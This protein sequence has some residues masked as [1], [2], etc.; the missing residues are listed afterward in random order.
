MEL[1]SPRREEG[2]MAWVVLHPH[3][4]ES[5]YYFAVFLSCCGGSKLSVFRGNRGGHRTTELFHLLY[6]GDWTMFTADRTVFSGK[7][8][9]MAF[10]SSTQAFK[11]RNCADRGRSR[12]F[13]LLFRGDWTMFAADRTLA[14]ECPRVPTVLLAQELGQRK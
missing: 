1:R 6:R 12:L 8:Q 14:Q 7:K 4:E 3:S 11:Q 5:E 2:L 9:R 10:V 13:H